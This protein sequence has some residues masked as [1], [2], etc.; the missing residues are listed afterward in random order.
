MSKKVIIELP[1]SYLFQGESGEIVL[2]LAD[3]VWSMSIPI[4][5]HHLILN[6]IEGIGDFDK[7]AYATFYSKKEK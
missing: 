5:K 6:E 1:N 7:T 2:H 3:M 4:E